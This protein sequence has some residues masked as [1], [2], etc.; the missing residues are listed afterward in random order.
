MLLGEAGDVL[1]LD[2]ELGEQQP[3]RLV[4][5]AEGRQDPGRLVGGAQAEK[6]L[7]GGLLP[8][9]AL[10]GPSL[11]EPFRLAELR[12]IVAQV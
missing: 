8:A 5:T 6:G 9:A 1:G 2:A 3:R 7:A 11:G 10:E 4:V 12:G